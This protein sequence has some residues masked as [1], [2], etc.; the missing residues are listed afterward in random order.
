MIKAPARDTGM[1]YQLRKHI[2]IQKAP[3]GEAES[4]SVAFDAFR[5]RKCPDAVMDASNTFSYPDC[6]VGSGITPDRA[7][8]GARGLSPP[9]G[10]FTLPRRSI[11][12]FVN[13]VDYTSPYGAGQLAH[14]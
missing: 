5:E 11:L 12:L 4:T 6:T 9:V 7:R 2:L 3:R 1:R 14:P 10:N 8:L 13:P